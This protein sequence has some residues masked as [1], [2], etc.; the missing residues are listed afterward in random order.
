M[1]LTGWLFWWKR[2]FLMIFDGGHVFGDFLILVIFE[3]GGV[4]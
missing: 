2:G 1:D 3:G 4:F